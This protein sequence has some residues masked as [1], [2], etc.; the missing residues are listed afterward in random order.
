[1]RGVFLYYSIMKK[2][3]CAIFLGI[4]FSIILYGFCIHD[5]N[6]SKTVDSVS[7]NQE[8][9]QYTIIYDLQ[10]GNNSILNPESFI[11][12]Q[13][14][15]KLENPQ[16]D[17]YHFSGW[18]QD[19]K[20][21]AVI[22]KITASKDYHLKAKWTRVISSL[23]SVETYPYKSSYFQE[24]I[25]LN[26]LNY[27]FI[28]SLD[29]PGNPKTKWKD[30][31]NRMIDSTNQCP[32]GIC[33]VDEYIV[34][35]S[36]GIDTDALGTMAFYRMSTGE[37]VKTFGMD[38]RSHLGGIAFDGK[39][40]WICNS[41]N[42][43]LERISLS[44]LK[45]IISVSSQNFIDISDCFDRYPVDTIPSC[46]CYYHGK[47]YVG[48]HRILTTGYAYEYAYQEQK[49]CLVYENKYR[50][51]AKTQGIFVNDKDQIYVSSS[52]GRTRASHLY[53]FDSFRQMDA[54]PKNP[55][56]IIQ[57]PPGAE[58]GYVFQGFIYLLFETACSKYY[59]GSDGG[60]NCPYPIDKVLVINEESI[61]FD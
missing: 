37:H 36:Y 41:N 59:E 32:Q 13:L 44:F 16:K 7:S 26:Q 49:N 14:P 31:R 30:Y 1:M 50:I 28:Y 10:G 48:S 2:I 55:N 46:I 3:R 52:Y 5:Y 18:I 22:W 23:D 27:H 6:N 54:S 60:G 35:T 42:H 19:T 34:I 25:P 29:V 15:L 53:L 11:S 8:E 40:L 39:N 57:M 58:G 4:I 33:I 12:S 21:D 61:F 51:P 9:K 17:G 43:E 56:A 45:K 20:N 47:L 38:S 24:E